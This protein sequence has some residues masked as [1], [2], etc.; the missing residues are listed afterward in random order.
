[1]FESDGLN[2]FIEG[3]S[4]EKFQDGSG[5]SRLCRGYDQKKLIEM[6]EDLYGIKKTGYL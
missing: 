3:T 4:K 2:F 1:M 5:I 6:F